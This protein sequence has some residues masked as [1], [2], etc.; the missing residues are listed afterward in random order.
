[1]T[2]QRQAWG[3]SSPASASLASP[4]A[5]FSRGMQRQE[6]AGGPNSRSFRLA[7][8]VAHARQQAMLWEGCTGPYQ[9]SVWARRRRHACSCALTTAGCTM[10]YTAMSASVRALPTMYVRVCRCSLSC[11]QQ[12][13]A[14]PIA[15]VRAAGSAAVPPRRAQDNRSIAGGRITLISLSS[16]SADS[17]VVIQMSHSLICNPTRRR[18]N[19]LAYTAAVRVLCNEAS[20]AQL[21]DRPAALDIQTS[22]YAVTVGIHAPELLQLGLAVPAACALM[23][24]R[25]PS[26]RKRSAGR[27]LVLQRDLPP[28][29]GHR[30]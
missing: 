9:R 27:L 13:Q 26:T 11:R 8:M 15:C 6:A 20:S 10:P 25:W 5:A 3:K 14:H 7:C 17:S 29:V 23:Y 12:Q 30:H 19:T 24:W 28:E 2:R 22:L 16:I 21:C 1:M 18:G 4:L